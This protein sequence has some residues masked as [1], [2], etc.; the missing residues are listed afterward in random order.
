[1]KYADDKN[2]PKLLKDFLQHQYVIKNRSK[3]T[4][5]EYALDLRMFL[6]YMLIH[7]GIIYKTENIENIN[8][9][10]FVDKD[11]LGSISLLDA[12]SF[13]AYCKNERHNDAAARARKVTSIRTF[14]KYLTVQ[15]S[16]FQKDP[17][18]ELESPKLKKTQPKYLTLDE[19][20]ALLNSVDGVY[21]ERD[22][23]I[24]T[25]FLNCGLRLSELC[26]INYKDIRSNNTLVVTGK[27]NKQRTI[28]LNKACISAIKNYMKVRPND[29]VKPDSREA[30]FLSAR[31]KRISQKTVQHIVYIYLEKA[32]LSG[33]GLSV[34][35]LRHTA[36][37]LM[38]RYGNVDVIALQE[39][40]GHENLGTTQIYTHVVD[41]QLKKAADSNPLADET[42]NTDN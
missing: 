21:K 20:K 12:Y 11:F 38:Y 42:T 3:L 15:R 27:G 29:K 19:S 36:A 18:Q 14:Y 9:N 41:E 37:T 7:K 1:M 28:Y 31:Y 32:G 10:S 39:I 13:L 22:Y 33:R 5:D 40:L 30:L 4:I 6:Y 16:L 24:L 2:L 23:A 34:H 8:F 17:M 35:K 25:L 26:S